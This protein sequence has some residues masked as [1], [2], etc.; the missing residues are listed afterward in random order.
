MLLQYQVERSY[1]NNA[2]ALP[3]IVLQN[4]KHLPL[5]L[6]CRTNQL[7][8]KLGA[9]IKGTVHIK[10]IYIYFFAETPVLY[11]TRNY[12]PVDK[13]TRLESS[14][15]KTRAELPGAAKISLPPIQ[16]TQVLIRKVNDT[17][18][19]KIN[20]DIIKKKDRCS[21]CV[22]ISPF[23]PFHHLTFCKHF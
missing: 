21:K 8:Q 6:P 19:F 11:F 7:T 2:E 14:A 9:W 13:K 17:K 10:S 1:G 4:V 22:F 3:V 20:K 18:K 12:D 15:R 23:L 16:H 5:W